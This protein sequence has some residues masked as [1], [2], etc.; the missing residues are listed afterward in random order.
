MNPF[1]LKRKMQTNQPTDEKAQIKSDTQQSKAK[2]KIERKPL[3][4]FKRHLQ[5]II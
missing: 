2:L 4:T 5:R 1:F 3:I